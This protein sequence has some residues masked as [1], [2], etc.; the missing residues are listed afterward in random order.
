MTIAHIHAAHEAATTQMSDMTVDLVAVTTKKKTSVTVATT[1]MI[2]AT[3]HSEKESE[4]C[5]LPGLVAQMF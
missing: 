2:L 1:A 4:I 3:S 5:H